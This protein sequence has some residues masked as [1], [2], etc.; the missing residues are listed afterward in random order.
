[1][2]KRLLILAAAVLLALVLAVPASASKSVP[3]VATRRAGV[4]LS[5]DVKPV[6]NR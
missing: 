4:W 5:G 1:M 3:I 6:G 2:K